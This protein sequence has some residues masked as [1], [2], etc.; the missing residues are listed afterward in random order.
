MANCGRTFRPCPCSAFWKRPCEAK[1][2]W[3][4]GP[5]PVYAPVICELT[6]SAVAMNKHG[7]IVEVHT[8]DDQMYYWSG[9]YKLDGSV[10][11]LHT[12]L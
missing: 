11:W 3:V 2:S 9:R 4:E 8:K 1:L 6:L 5:A 10:E 7:L 12:G